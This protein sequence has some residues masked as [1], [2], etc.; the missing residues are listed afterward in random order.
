MYLLE[1]V[2]LPGY[3]SV[4]CRQANKAKI[5]RSV[6]VLQV[7]C[8]FSLTLP[9]LVGFHSRFAHIAPSYSKLSSCETAGESAEAYD[10]TH[11]WWGRE[12]SGEWKATEGQLLSEQTHAIALHS[13]LYKNT[14]GLQA[15][16]LTYYVQH[17]QDETLSLFLHSLLWMDVGGSVQS[18]FVMKHSGRNIL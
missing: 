11:P 1:I 8:L 15:C 16:V 2:I 3:W 9:I 12:G 18:Y 10:I 17:Y 7:L 5:K 13:D 6:F 14:K 4:K